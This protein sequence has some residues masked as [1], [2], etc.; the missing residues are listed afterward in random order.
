MSSSE[1]LVVFGGIA[2]IVWINWYFF[3]AQRS[4]MTGNGKK[5]GK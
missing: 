3:L 4:A 5:E 1:W 2:A